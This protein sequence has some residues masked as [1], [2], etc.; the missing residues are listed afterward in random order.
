MKNKGE[1]SVAAQARPFDHYVSLGYNCE[2]S[3]RIQDYLGK[4]IESYPLTWAYVHD[5]SRLAAALE[6]RGE[7]LGRMLPQKGSDMF[8]DADYDIAFHVRASA[9]ELFRADGSLREEIA[10]PALEE[11]RSRYRHLTEK[12]SELLLS[13]DRTLFV[14][15]VREDGYRQS[16]LK[17]LFAFLVENYF[18][19]SGGFRLLVVSEE[20]WFNEKEA[21]RFWR[22]EDRI[23]FATVENFAADDKTDRDGDI[24]GWMRAFA[25]ADKDSASFFEKNKK[26]NANKTVRKIRLEKRI[27]VSVLIPVYNTWRTLP[28]CLD[29]VLSQTLREIEIVCADDAS[30]QKTKDV[31]REYAEKDPRIRII[32]FPQNKGTL[33]VRSALIR[34][35]RGDYVMF[36]DSDDEFMPKAC[37]TA[38]HAIEKQRVDIVQFGTQIV[39][40]KAMSEGEKRDLYTYFRLNKGRLNG[41]N[42]FKKCFEFG[43]TSYNWVLWDKI[44]RRSIIQKVI[45]YLPEVRCLTAEDFAIYFIAS[46]YARSFYGIKEPLIRYYFGAGVSASFRWTLKDYRV[47]LGRK[48]ACDIVRTMLDTENPS[49][50]IYR[51]SYKQWE[52]EFFTAFIWKF[53]EECGLSSG[54]EVFDLLAEAYGLPRLIYSF[55]KYLG[56]WRAERLA[57]LIRDASC[58]KSETKPIRTIG[59]FYHRIGIG[60]VERVLSKLIPLF[61][62]WGYKTVL[63]VEEESDTDYSIPAQCKKIIVPGSVHIDGDAY[64]AHGEALL[65][66]L[67]ENAV[68]VLL[69]QAGSS[70][71][72]LYDILIA[73]AAGTKIAVTLHELVAL[74][75]IRDR[76]AFT[77]KPYYLRLADGVQTIVR[78]DE[79]LLQNFGIN[80]RFIPNPYTYEAEESLQAR[81]KDVLWVGRMEPVQKRPEHAIE[82]MRLVVDELPDARMRIVG[83]ADSEEEEKRYRM[84]IAERGLQENIEMCGFHSDPSEFYRNSGVLL[85]TSR[86]E[87]APM[88][89]G[90][91]MSFGLPIVT[92]DMPYVEFL[93]ENDGCVRVPQEDIVGA[94]KELVRILQD[95]KLRGELAQKS[96]RTARKLSEFDL[97]AAWDEFL[98]GLGEHP[99]SDEDMRICLENMY[100]F[101]DLG[102]HGGEKSGLVG[103][104]WRY[105]KDFGIAATFRKTIKFIRK[106]GFKATVNRLL[107][108]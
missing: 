105:M 71:W 43:K 99:D 15:K 98:C 93:R 58:L 50:S 81:G 88:V 87:V 85:M 26:H 89:L 39:T 91:A 59:F 86:Y 40:E 5:L 18:A 54:A 92:Y 79:A 10:E 23:L 73:K 68:D 28:R 22:G 19:L 97:H 44:F 42:V 6:K 64:A 65:D 51:E 3:F 108:K 106:Y 83:K 53:C 100:E 35:A 17:N 24:D 67:K 52:K 94:A 30:D 55:A 76:A 61:L 20:R 25:Y 77:N 45:P 90:E 60:G 84:Q 80:A 104:A 12:F 16:W 107:H 48:V 31:L 27:R 62:N 29:S 33:C 75:L 47:N 74:P 101:Y 14:L 57:K 36:L 38:L 70:Q 7:L 102:L 96:L 78:S 56:N 37:E 69:Y 66:G 21:K 82:I 72:L 103:F 63:F 95:D 46:Y 34:A 4:P 2:V 41:T 49:D 9:D 11:L 1:E 8:R 13:D 32:T